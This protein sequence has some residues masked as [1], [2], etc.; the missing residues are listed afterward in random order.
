MNMKPLSHGVL[1]S[2][3]YENIYEVFTILSGSAVEMQLLRS[4][5][6]RFFFFFFLH[7]VIGGGACVKGHSF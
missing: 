5:D 3:K 1:H 4:S 6:S 7:S 2:W